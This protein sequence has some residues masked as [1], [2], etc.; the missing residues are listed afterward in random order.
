MKPFNHLHK[1]VLR[2]FKF[3]VCFCLSDKLTE[4]EGVKIIKDGAC[5]ILMI[6]CCKKDDNAVYRFEAEG[7]KSEATLNVQGQNNNFEIRF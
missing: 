6:E 1:N 7:R 3:L 4:E 5:H 2:F